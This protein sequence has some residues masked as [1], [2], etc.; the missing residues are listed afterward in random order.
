MEASLAPQLELDEG[1]RAMISTASESGNRRLSHGT[2]SGSARSDPL[3]HVGVGSDGLYHCPYG[4]QGTCL[5]RP[6]NLKCNYE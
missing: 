5:H 6:T 2:R 1:S 3:Y 4:N